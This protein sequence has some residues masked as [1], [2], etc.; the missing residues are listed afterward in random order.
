[1]AK[2]KELVVVTDGM[3]SYPPEF[4]E[5]N[6][7]RSGN[8]YYQLVCHLGTK[9]LMLIGI[10]DEGFVR[11]VSVDVEDRV[12]ALEHPE[13]PRYLGGESAVYGS[14]VLSLVVDYDT[15]TPNREL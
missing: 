8:F 12:D 4:V 13:L 3:E 7:R 2:S 6:G 11:S 15:L 1:M 9:T 5:I 10:E 14:Q